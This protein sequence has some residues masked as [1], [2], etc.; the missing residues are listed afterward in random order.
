VA[1]HK[2]NAKFD[3]ANQYRRVPPAYHQ[4]ID[5]VFAPSGVGVQSCALLLH[6]QSGRFVGTMPSD[7]NPLECD[8][9]LPY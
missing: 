4:N 6:L 8:L 9:T 2:S 1:Q 3:S 5:H 7:H